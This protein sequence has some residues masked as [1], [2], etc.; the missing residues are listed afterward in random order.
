MIRGARKGIGLLIVLVLLVAGATVSF[1]AGGKEAG[2]AKGTVT[3]WDSVNVADPND[4]NVV[5][6][7]GNMDA[8]KAKYPNINVERTIV[9]NGDEYL[10]KITTAMAAG[11]APDIF[12]TWLSG[13]LEPFVTAGRVIPLDDIVNGDSD[14]KDTITPAFLDTGTFN[15]HVYALAT[16]L[17]AEV[18][19]YNK[20]I[21]S[22]YGLSV[23]A[24]FGDLMKIVSTLKANGIVPFAMG[25]KDPWVGSIPF[26][27]IFDR[28]GGQ[29]IY[30][31]I[32]LAH[33]SKWNDPAFV[34]AAKYLL[35]LRDAGA[36]PDNFNAMDY[37]EAVQLFKDG[38]AGM[39]FNGT[40]E[41][42]SLLKAIP[43]KDLGF[44]NFP[45]IPGGKGTAKSF[46]LNKDE[47]YAIS[48]NAKNKD[49]AVLL[50]KLMF[51]KD[52]QKIR[53]EAGTLVTTRNLGIDES[54]LPAITVALL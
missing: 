44:F 27:A 37:N 8:F 5:W 24:T 43:D 9:S 46:L 19:F 14:L 4:P 49:G 18:V 7:Q 21:F 1:A 53:A 23:P 22:Q 16:T 35:Q 3:Y 38:K 10:N 31:D 20:A 36:Y 28:V 50:L 11:N 13:R 29:Q 33:T 40:W 30:K 48:S 15:G 26:M 51:S 45:D 2:G 52:R 47:G 54:K 12:Q 17:T 39:W 42:A 41:L 32:M 6:Q 34:Q 25:N